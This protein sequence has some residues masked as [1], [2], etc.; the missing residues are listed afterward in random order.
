MVDLAGYCMPLR[1]RK[2]RINRHI[3][4]RTQPVAEPPCS[5]LREV[6]YTGNVACGVSYLLYH[7]GS[8][9]VQQ[10]GEDGLARLPDDHQ[11]R[12]RDQ[13]PPR[14]GRRVGIRATLP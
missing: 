8:H 7:L 1:N 9:P 3:D 10:A 5:D 14:W 6:L 2:V 12:C 4:L 13:E 11:D